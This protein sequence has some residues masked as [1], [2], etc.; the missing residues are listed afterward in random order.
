M[1]Y[2]Y[3][4]NVCIIPNLVS[5][6]PFP[7]ATFT[8]ICAESSSSFSGAFTLLLVHRL[9]GTVKEG[10]SLLQLQ[11]ELKYNNMICNYLFTTWFAT[12]QIFQLWRIKH[13]GCQCNACYIH[14]HH[15]NCIILMCALFIWI[16]IAFP[17]MSL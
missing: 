8:T 16:C 14:V 15:R 12:N 9:T 2:G 11:N 6:R 7:S 13:I 5:T 1:H 17:V 4:E 10:T 3:I